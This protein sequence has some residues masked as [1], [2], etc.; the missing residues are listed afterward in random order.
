MLTEFRGEPVAGGTLPALIW[1]E[2]MKGVEDEGASFTPAPYIGSTS[3]W[4]VQRGGKWQL[5][6]GYCRGARLVAYFSGHGPETTADCKP[7]EVSVPLVVGM[8]V[9][10]AVAQLGSQPLE[11][12]IAYVPA[13]AGT[14]PGL[15]VNQDPRRGGLSANDDVQLWVSKAQHGA[16][17][18][19]VG[20]SVEDVNRELRRLRLRV[21]A[22]S[23]PGPAG[24]VLRQRPRA[25][26]AVRPGLTVR[27]V[28][29]DGS[30]S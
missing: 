1:R 24:I 19:L 15:V 17:P 27:L 4:V 23:A 7:N 14:I 2:F 3:S 10:E 29:G 16:L 21:R 20:S 13:K 28:V 5:D 11:A 9:D 26:I 6:N 25:G 18:N 12:E 8:T 22:A 30:G